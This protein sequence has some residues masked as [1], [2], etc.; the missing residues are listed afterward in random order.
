VYTFFFVSSWFL[1]YT[2]GFLSC[3]GMNRGFMGNDIETD[4]LAERAAL[5]NRHDVSFLDGK[6]RRAVNGDILVPL[7]ETTVLGDVVKVIPSNDDGTL[8]L[9]AQH[10]TLED[11]STDRYIAREGAFLVNVGRFQCGGGGLDAQTDRLGETHGLLADI[12]N[13]A[14]PSHK[15]GILRLV[16]LFVLIALHVITLDARHVVSK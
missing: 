2:K 5:S 10:Q 4:R 9:G 14:L 3:L 6:C 15:D 16:G 1:K 12:S 11:T 13:G 8:H 7:L